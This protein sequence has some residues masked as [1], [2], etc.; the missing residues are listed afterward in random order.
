MEPTQM[1]AMGGGLA[2]TFGVGIYALTASLVAAGA[3]APF[4]LAG[5]VIL[6]TAILALGYATQ[7]LN[8]GGLDNIM[9]ISDLSSEKINAL[10]ALFEAASHARPLIVIHSPVKVE[11]SVML[12]GGDTE[13]AM[14]KGFVTKVAR[15][16]TD[17]VDS[18]HVLQKRGTSPG[19]PMRS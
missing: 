8:T 13:I 16:I 11:G 1:L 5:I 15:E 2:F 12:E 10:K 17:T 7:S 9:K 14:T 19:V 3:A 6:T 4:A 18:T